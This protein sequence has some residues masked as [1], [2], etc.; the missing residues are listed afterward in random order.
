MIYARNRYVMR[1]KAGEAVLDQSGFV[2]MYIVLTKHSAIP[3]LR[4][5]ALSCMRRNGIFGGRV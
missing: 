2:G 3:L 4:F 1:E 5:P